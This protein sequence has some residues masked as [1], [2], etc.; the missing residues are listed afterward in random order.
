MSPIRF[1]IVH[2]MKIKYRCIL[3]LASRG[4]ANLYGA[5]LRKL[6]RLVCRETARFS[7]YYIRRLITFMSLIY[8]RCNNNG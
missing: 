3:Y 1:N 2:K 7:D 6:L 5:H 8:L 4:F